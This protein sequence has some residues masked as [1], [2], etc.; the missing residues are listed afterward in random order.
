MLAEA[1]SRLEMIEASAAR[2]GTF[3][4]S[5]VALKKLAARA[6]QLPLALEAA[7]IHEEAVAELEKDDD[8]LLE[9]AGKEPIQ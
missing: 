9:I 2:G 5:E 6:S 1:E 3:A 4:D 7:R 8:G